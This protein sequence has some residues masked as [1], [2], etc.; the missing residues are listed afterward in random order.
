MVNKIT[1]SPRGMNQDITKSKHPTEFY[2]EGKNIR[3]TTTDNQSTGAISNEKG[4]TLEL[5]IPDITIDTVANTITYNTDVLSYS[6]NNEL[7]QQIFAGNAVTFSND[8]Q[9]IGYTLTR[10]SIILFSHGNKLDCIWEVDNILDNND[11]EITLLYC[12]NLN[13]SSAIQAIYNYENEI[14]EKVYWVD[15]IN[16]TRFINLR[17]SIENGDLEELIDLESNILNIVSDFEI[18]QPIITDVTTG[19][20]HTAG[21]IQYAYNLYRLNSAQSKISPLT[22]L[23]PLDKGLFGGGDVDEEVGAVPIIEVNDLDESFTHIKLYGIKYT[24]FNQLPFVALLVDEEIPSTRTI[25]HY[26]DGNFIQEISLDEFL[27][28]GSDPIVPK[29]IESKD[30][31]LFSANLTELV[32]DLDIDCRAYSFPINSTTTTVLDN[33]RYINGV[34]PFTGALSNIGGDIATI[35][36]TYILEEK[37]D[38]VNPNYDYFKFQYNSNYLGG[39]GKYL[40]YYLSQ[41][42][43]VNDEDYQFFKDREIYRL[44]IQFYNRL[45]QTSP[46]KWIADIKAP[47]GNMTQ[48]FN[49]LKVELKPEFYTAIIGL[50]GDDKPVGY[51]IMRADRTYTDRTIICQGS[52][53]G[54]MSNGTE[55]TNDSDNDFLTTVTREIYKRSNKLPSLQRVYDDS[56][57]PMF[58]MQDGRKLDPVGAGHPGGTATSSGNA[59]REVIRAAAGSDMRSDTF[60]YNKIIQLFSPEILFENVSLGSSLTLNIVG[61]HGSS[62]DYY[63]GREL[64][65]NGITIEEEGKV[66]GGIS[67]H[68]STLDS[69]VSIN[70]SVNSLLDSGIFGPSRATNMEFNQFF[71]EFKGDWYASA[72]G[73]YY[74]IYGTPE[75]TERGQ[76]LTYYNNNAAT[77]YAYF[78]T[79]EPMITDAHTASAAGNSNA[80]A[81]T[82]VNSH[83]CKC[84]TLVLG[85]DDTEFEARPTLESV[86]TASGIAE[87]H[88]ILLGELALRY[89]DV[90]LGNIY[91]GNSYESKGRNTY[92][93]IGDYSDISNGT[94]EILS[95]GDTYVQNFRFLKITPTDIQVLDTNSEQIVEIVEY[96]V[97]T[98]VDLKNRNDLSLNNW[99]A[100]FQPLEPTYHK[101]NRV[102]SQQPTLIQYTTDNSEKEI[103]N[104]DTRII[105]SKV[106]VPGER[107]DSWTDTLV[108]E[109]QDLDGKYGPINS[110]VNFNDKIFSLQDEGVALVSIN[111][112]VQVQGSDGISVELGKGSVLHDYDYITTKAGTINKWSTIS[113]NDGFYFYDA[114]NKG[115]MKWSGQGLQ[116][117]T[118]IQGLHSYFDKNVNYSQI[119]D[120]NPLQY[121]VVTGYHKINHD[122]YLTIKQSSGSFTLCY[123]EVTGSFVSFYDYTPSFYINKGFKMITTNPN[124]NQLWE[125]FKGDYNSFYGNIYDSSVTYL[126]NPQHPDCVFNNIEYKSEFYLDG[127]DVKKTLTHIQAWNEYQQ[128]IETP[129]ILNSNL[130]RKFRMWRANIP[131]NYD[132]VPT[133]DR[134]RGHWIFLKVLLKDNPNYEMILHDMNVYYNAY[135]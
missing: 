131:R 85:T 33:V 121:G 13:F 12:R 35:T 72:S 65:L 127:V 1:F 126:V 68:S 99:D 10:N 52:L 46:V 92:L 124:R 119:K 113:T 62:K 44:G 38:A 83:G 42:N 75:L 50:T 54:M 4:N 2:F 105:A 101:Y 22:K 11:Y 66:V 49:T 89:T 100:K 29:H 69:E 16:Q 104:F 84:V 34:L 95:P 110:L 107:I 36:N 129:L 8:Q 5:S 47:S 53:N 133:L 116:K 70:G 28:L 128:T 135:R 60:Q 77:E 9:I 71:R 114:L 117:I 87:P 90:Y 112:R 120:D 25:T 134:M 55:R 74:D 17:H 59:N 111:P 57:F 23:I 31:Y 19:G 125:H 24:S 18:S 48:N 30:N 26:D 39:E 122:V 27:F 80:R 41:S 103:V 88:S 130:N 102:Y 45:G 20:T 7:E 79:L 61:A 81:I 94:I 3:I 96:K 21:K 78:N 123:N 108:N 51:K 56:V 97:E 82:S 67:P 93:E 115:W 6:D 73:V 14:I 15:G 118:D 76:G 32:F 132:N 64:D 58:G 109:I 63:W 40:K 37:H 98:T 91:G 106:K 43:I 86:F